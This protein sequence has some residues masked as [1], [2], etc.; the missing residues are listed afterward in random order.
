MLKEN[1]D[2]YAK[3]YRISQ[4]HSIKIKIVKPTF[5]L[6]KVVK[7]LMKT[8][9]Q[10]LIFLGSFNQSSFTFHFIYVL[11]G[12]GEIAQCLRALASLREGLGSGPST[13]TG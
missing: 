3:F 7:F 1:L 4:F 13:H 2:Y 12:V 6:K 11:H 5:K 9:F 8:I 10:C